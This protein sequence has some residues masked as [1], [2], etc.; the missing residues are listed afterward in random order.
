MRNYRFF[1]LLVLLSVGAHAKGTSNSNKN[2]SITPIIGVERVQ[3]IVPTPT[4]KTRLIYGAQVLYKLPITTAE[5]EFTHAQDTS[6]DLTSGT[7]YKDVEDK[8]K[9]GLRG[10]F[11]I[12]SFLSAYLRGGAQARQNKNTQTTL[13]K[14]V[15]SSTKSKVNPYVGTGLAIH[16]MQYFSLS[17]DLTAVY[18]PTTNPA[19]SP[20]EL[21]PSLGV[22]MGF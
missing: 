17:A 8:V 6:T 22:S 4:M 1:V 21:Q 7:G 14:V 18:V 2:L 16:V 13:A 12:A 9:L 5:M 20:Y 19:L 10:N 11:E 3:K 15:T